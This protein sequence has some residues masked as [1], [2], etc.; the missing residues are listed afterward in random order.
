[1]RI[2]V[3][4]DEKKIRVLLEHMIQQYGASKCHNIE[5]YTFASGESLLKWCEEFQQDIHLLFLDIEMEGMS[6]LE[7]KD[8][9]R[10]KENVKRIVILTSHTESM[11]MA[12]GLK[13]V[14]FLEKPMDY[15]T[16]EKMMD[17]V[18]EELG[19]TR[20]IEYK[21]GKTNQGISSENI[22]YI[23]SVKDYSIICNEQGEETSLITCK[24]KDW[25]S[26]LKGLSFIR[27]HKSYIVNL[28]YVVDVRQQVDLSI[29]GESLPLGR[30]YR[31]SA[32]EAYETYLRKLIR[33]R[34]L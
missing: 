24:L 18:W 19:E 17:V 27:I 34:L 1:M 20:W 29:S 21:V 25:E 4:D 3:C 8:L 22:V 31:E 6:G 2:A 9:L 32:R 12:F 16:M 23:R 15:S 5:I 10:D 26:Q 13:V 11:Q 30:G 14:N 33:K 7:V 28:A